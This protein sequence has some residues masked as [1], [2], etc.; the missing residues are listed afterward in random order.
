MAVVRDLRDIAVD[1]GFG[2]SGGGGSAD[3]KHASH[4]SLGQASVDDLERVV[5]EG[6]V[7]ASG[8]GMS[9]KDRLR[10][11]EKDVAEGGPGASFVHTTI[12]PGDE[13]VFV[14]ECNVLVLAEDRNM[15]EQHL[16]QLQVRVGVFLCSLVLRWCGGKRCRL[17]FLVEEMYSSCLAPLG[18][19]KPSAGVMKASTRT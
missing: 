8:P 15:A 5:G 6:G 1:A 7:P 11:I 13:F 10:V 16:I 17:V 9:G 18:R 4:I 2:D 12:F 3:D 14:G 19:R